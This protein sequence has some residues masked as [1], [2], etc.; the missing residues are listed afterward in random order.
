MTEETEKYQPEEALKVLLRAGLFKGLPDTALQS[1]VEV[2]Q[3]VSVPAGES[4]F[5]EGDAGDA[6]YVMADGVM[7]LVKAVPGGGEETLAVRRAGD[8]FGEM[9]I[10]NDAP[11]S[12][13]ARAV[14]DS[15]LLLVPRE[16]FEALLGGDGLSLRMMKAL[17][18]AL[19]A[20]DVRFVHLEHKF[21][22][23]SQ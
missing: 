20:L 23:A 1:V 14:E 4:L 12:A 18:I 15:E 7:A 13:T 17:S 5:E 2:A 19:R 8:A 16:D 6:F 3:S 22:S 11:R 9:A 10:L 21:L